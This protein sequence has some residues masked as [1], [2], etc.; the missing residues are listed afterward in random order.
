VP[1]S[2]TVRHELDAYLL[3]WLERESCWAEPWKLWT[4]HTM[5]G[6]GKALR[7]TLI[8]DFY[9]AASGNSQ[10]RPPDSVLRLGLAVEFLHTFTLIHDDLPCM[11]DDDFRRG[12]PTLHRLE[13]DAIA[14]L[15]GDVLHS[16]ATELLVTSDLAESHKIWAIRELS[17]RMGASGL[18]EGQRLD[19][20]GRSQSLDELLKVHALKT[21]ELFSL[22]CELG[23]LAALGVRENLL[24]SARSWGRTFGLLF[25][26]ADDLL[27]DR[28]TLGQMG[29]TPGK[30]FRL[31]RKT[32]LNFIKASDL[33]LFCADKF[34][35]LHRL[36]LGFARPEV[37]E[38]RFKVLQK[39]INEFNL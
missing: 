9:L 7:P 27:D 13:S 14:V 36:S 30:D 35:E 12:R 32:I 21:G 26:I 11:D 15:T 28:A 1:R 4:K 22:S 37:L 16:A 10:A 5:L 8:F 18:F 31:G 23:V 29:K 33:R 38:S 19:V 24:D 34:D 3:R 39:S 20:E 25:Q 17:Q 6:A 2:Q